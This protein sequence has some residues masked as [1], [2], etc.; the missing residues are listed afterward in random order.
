MPRLVLDTNVLVSGLINAHG[1]SARLVDAVRA[2]LLD[3]AACPHLL[4]ELQRTLA[5]P[6]MSRYVTEDDTADYVAAVSAWSTPYPDPVDF[7]EAVCRDPDDAY[8]V[9]LY[10]VAHADFLVSGDK[11]FRG[12]ADLAFVL[13]PRQAAD[14]FVHD[15]RR[16]DVQTSGRQ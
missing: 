2:G 16:G 14:R 3:L 6:R 15:D 12:A 1:P 10:N 4:E 9:A 8:L 5:K 11:D 7:D 13:T